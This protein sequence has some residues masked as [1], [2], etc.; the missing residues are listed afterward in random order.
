MTL[1][2]TDFLQFT[3]A[4]NQLPQAQ[5]EAV[6]NSLANRRAKFPTRDPENDNREMGTVNVTVT[7][8]ED[9]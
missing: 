2:I 6:G 1:D 8:R 7:K 3:K 9:L 5:R 4:M